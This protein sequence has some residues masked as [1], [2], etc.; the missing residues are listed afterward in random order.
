MVNQ[1]LKKDEGTDAPKFLILNVLPSRP[2]EEFFTK[3]DKYVKNLYLKR[4]KTPSTR[5]ENIVG[6]IRCENARKDIEE[7][8]VDIKSFKDKYALLLGDEPNQ[9]IIR[10]TK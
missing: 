5:I 6:Q 8:T 3:R 1:L 7:P 2:S 9:D 10:I 4:F